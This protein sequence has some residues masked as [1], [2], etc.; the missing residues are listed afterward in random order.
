[1][2]NNNYQI[3]VDCGFSRLRVSAFH[4]TN[5]REKFHIE[6]KFLFDHSEIDLE[7]QRIITSLEK[8]TDE[9][10]DNINLMIDSPK[11]I[12]IGISI[13]KKIDGLQVRQKDIKFLVQEAKQQIIKYYKNKNITHIIINNYKIN[14][15]DYDY[16]P[17]NTKCNFIALDILFICLPDETIE[18][19]KRFF[20]K[21][22]I[23]INQITC[24]SYAK[25]MNYKNN[26]SLYKNISFIDFGFNKTSITTYNNNKITS[27]DVMPVGGNHITKDISKVLRID[28][29]QAENIKTHFDKKN[30]FLNDKEFSLELL[31]KI[32]FARTD[33]ILENCTQSI[34]LKFNT[35]D[36]YKIILIGEGSK[37]LNNKYKGETSFPHS[38]DFLEETS[39][40]IC[41]S[42]FKLMTSLNKQ[43][44]VVI[45]KKQ[46]KQGFF[47]K[48]FHFFN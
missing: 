31:K 23:S 8:N 38:I 43:E 2:N 34:K 37:V 18:Y 35:I 22:N 29:D 42:G 39:E 9:Y 30:T 44:V 25:A 36:K 26:F 14:N 4:K 20:H 10:I 46:I 11:M 16:L 24:S 48:L 1:M 12:S 13:A 19:F 47:E 33:E 15:T 40:G 3:Y 7:A 27:L 45:P 32:I 17:L 5:L 41:Q 21:F 28:L 6:S